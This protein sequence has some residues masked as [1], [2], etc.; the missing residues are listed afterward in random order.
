[1]INF[2]VKK[3][4]NIKISKN[5][6]FDINNIIYKYYKNNRL[7]ITAKELIVTHIDP[8]IILNK[9]NTKSKL[10]RLN[11]NLDSPV[12]THFQL[13]YK[14]NKSDIYNENNSY[15]VA[16]KKGNNKISLSIPAKYIN[17]QLRVDLVA[18]IG[19]YKINDFSI[20]EVE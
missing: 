16:I 13:F 2:I 9:L 7:T 5:K 6:I 10:I 18:K 17:N 3:Y 14:E 11:Y 19:T 1:L 12:K 20:H 8:V 15:R 4:L